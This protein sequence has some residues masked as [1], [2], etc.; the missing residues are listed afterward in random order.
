M[1]KKEED[2]K[3]INQGFYQKE[4]LPGIWFFAGNPDY[5]EDWG[6]LSIRIQAININ[7]DNLYVPLEDTPVYLL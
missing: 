1:D 4:E 2:S 7:I 3:K 5:E 6:K